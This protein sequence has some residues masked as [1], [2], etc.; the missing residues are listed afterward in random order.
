MLIV[1]L[2]SNFWVLKEALTGNDIFE[3]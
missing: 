1:L 3:A 2:F